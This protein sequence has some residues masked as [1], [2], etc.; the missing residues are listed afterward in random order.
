MFKNPKLL[1]LFF[2]MV[3]MMLGF[4]I[5]IPIMPFYI[6]R[7]GAGGTELGMMMAV[8]SIMQFLFSPF[9]G[10]LS[11]RFGRKKI[12]MIG[13]LGNAFS[14]VLIGLAGN[15]GVVFLSRV[16]AGLFSAATMPTA[17]AYIGDSTRPDERS[18]G[19]G[20]IGAAMGVGMVLGP[21]VGGW[22]TAINL[23]F[24][25]FM[26]AAMSLVALATIYIILPESLPR[27]RRTAGGSWMSEVRNFRGPNLS[28]LWKELFGPLG[29][30]MLLAFLVNFALAN[31]EGIFALFAD[32]TYGYS[33]AQ[34]GS[35]FMVVGTI[36]S[37]VQMVLTG[38][39]ARKFGETNVIKGSLL[40]SA[41]GFILM[42]LAPNNILVPVTVGFFV[43]S[44]AMLRPAIQ[45][46]TSMRA[47]GGQGAVL[48]VNNAYQSLGRVAGPM[49]A[50]SLFDVNSYL[51]YISGAVIL[52]LAFAYSLYAMRARAEEVQPAPIIQP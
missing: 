36:G 22:L 11:D 18:G 21:G 27:E 19:M 39:A 25:F 10:S 9:W 48:G 40:G 12:M 43:F 38:P 44:N 51:P 49:W 46:V 42:A 31:F 24:P 26:A 35:V 8:F 3:V 15:M 7:F 33:P 5:V 13:T 37:L 16:I 6:E 52:F 30:L 47:R 29:F 14:M 20:I 17:M 50:G 45:S 1:T 2:T 23:S 32:R 34:V 4:G 28:L 41:I